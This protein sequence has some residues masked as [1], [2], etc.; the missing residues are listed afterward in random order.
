M[1]ETIDELPDT[2]RMFEI[3]VKGSEISV[4]PH[5]LLI[6]SEGSMRIYKYSRNLTLSLKTVIECSYIL[7]MRRS[8]G[9]GA[10]A[11]MHKIILALFEQNITSEH[12][13]RKHISAVNEYLRMESIGSVRFVGNV[14]KID[15][16][17]G[18]TF[19]F[20][21]FFNLVKATKSSR[22]ILKVS[23]KGMVVLRNGSIVTSK[24]VE[25]VLQCDRVRNLVFFLTGASIVVA[26]FVS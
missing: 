5:F 14:V 2:I 11:L 19:Y 15:Y 9:K 4:S 25:N 21:S 1:C 26:Q 20:D 10:R 7:F 16:R 17:C 24:E 8:L 23:K 22:D 13:M 3:P 18:K 12:L 6:A